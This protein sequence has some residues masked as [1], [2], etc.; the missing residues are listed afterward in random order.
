MKDE[1]FSS[2]PQISHRPWIQPDVIFLINVNSHRKQ[3][4]SRELPCRDQTKCNNIHNFQSICQV[5]A[6]GL[7]VSACSTCTVYKQLKASRPQRKECNVN[8]SNINAM[9]DSVSCLSTHSWAEHKSYFLHKT[10]LC[11]QQCWTLPNKVNTLVLV[12]IC[13]TWGRQSCFVI[14][15]VSP[16]KELMWSIHST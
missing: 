15:V 10:A 1:V 7:Y 5:S 14:Y 3:K 6:S 4:R 13:M 16:H 9:Q 2:L 12:S 8:V 11:K